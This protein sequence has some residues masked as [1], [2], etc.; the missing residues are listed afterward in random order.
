MD[1]DIVESPKSWL[2]V[3]APDLPEVVVVKSVMTNKIIQKNRCISIGLF[4]CPPRRILSLDWMNNPWRDWENSSSSRYGKAL[5]PPPFG[6]PYLKIA[7]LN[8]WDKREAW[9]SATGYCR[10]YLLI[11]LRYTSRRPNIS[12]SVPRPCTWSDH[13]NISSCP[14]WSHCHYHY[15]RTVVTKQSKRLDQKFSVSLN[16]ILWIKFRSSTTCFSIWN[17]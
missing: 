15:W 14:G 13:L 3:L 8:E 7:F 11:K 5:F 17:F 16:L 12:S 10:P 2:V 1:V 6:L 4:L 9:A